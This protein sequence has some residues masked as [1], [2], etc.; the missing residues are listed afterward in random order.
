MYH[1]P[2]FSI[3]AKTGKWKC[4]HDGSGGDALDFYLRISE[5]SVK[6]GVK[7]LLTT[8]VELDGV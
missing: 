6:D 2:S 1:H 7:R 3:D 5:L 4:F 8:S